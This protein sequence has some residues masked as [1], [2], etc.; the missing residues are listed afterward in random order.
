[1][2]LEMGQVVILTRTFQ[3]YQKTQEKRIPYQVFAE[4]RLCEVV[5]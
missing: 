1:M 3:I 5:L 2:D 4:I